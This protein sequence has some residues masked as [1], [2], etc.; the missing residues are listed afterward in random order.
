M[1]VHWTA[2][3][4]P[5]LSGKT[6]IVTG[7]NSGIGFEAADALAAKSAAVVLACR[8]KE[9]GAAAFERILRRHPAAKAEVIRL[10]LEKLSSV[11]GFAREF[12]DRFDRLD[13]LINNAGIMAVPRGRTAD[14]FER[15]FGVNHL[16]H[17]ALTGLLIDRIL[18]APGA[19]VVTVSSASHPFTGIDF[20]NLNGEKSYGR[21]RAYVQS[22][23][24]NLLFMFELQR[25][26]E[27]AGARA[28]SAAAHPGWTTTRL[29]VHLPVV[30][31]LSGAFA[32]SPAMGA[33][34]ILYA[35]AAPDVRGGDYI[36]PAGI[37]HLSGYPVRVSAGA[38][39]RDKAAAEKLWQ[40]SESMTG[41][42]YLS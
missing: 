15:Q 36:G 4:I 17:F 19:R 31:A 21:W 16:G 20:G 9:R 11:R 34:P 41:I 29:F 33:L 27:R 14:G 13:I 32:Q 26:F 23:L 22:K 12:A 6:A 39:A 37:F 3:N 25:R 5:D 2:E 10:D 18:Q 28:L 24:A 40:V 42:R 35:A 8:N 7:A 38:G 30:G 1:A